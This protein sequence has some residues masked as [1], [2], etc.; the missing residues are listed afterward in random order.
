VK[1]LHLRIHGRV[2]G[3]GYR[4]ALRF[5]AERR[6]VSGWV[7]NRADGTVEALV[8]GPAGVLAE[9]AE[10]CRKGPALA[11]VQRVDAGPPPATAEPA[12]PWPAPA[13]PGF[14]RLPSV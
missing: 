4:E 14:L 9:L 13:G 6:G 10:W 7:R 3:V 12:L 5:E 2:Q 8:C 1:T 11:R